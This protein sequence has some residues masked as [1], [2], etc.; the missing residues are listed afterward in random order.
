M[1]FDDFQS[2][3]ITFEKINLEAQVAGAVKRTAKANRSRARLIK[4]DEDGKSESDG[5][6]DIQIGGHPAKRAQ[7]L[8]IGQQSRSKPGQ[9][10][11]QVESLKKG[12]SRLIKVN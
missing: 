12:P 11:H 3:P 1:I 9:S 4:P 7:P 5:N 2:I 8:S 6:P 10:G